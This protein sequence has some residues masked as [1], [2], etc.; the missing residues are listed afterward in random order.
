MEVSKR[1]VLVF[2]IRYICISKLK[3]LNFHVNT[4]GNDKEEPWYLF[5][6]TIAYELKLKLKFLKGLFCFLDGVVMIC[7]RQRG[8]IKY[9]C[10]YKPRRK[11]NLP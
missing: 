9:G 4:V 10:L 7:Y 2:S 8:K 6:N 3:T 1:L 11:Y 5:Q